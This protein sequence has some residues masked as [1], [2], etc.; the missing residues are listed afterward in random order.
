MA[1]SLNS[2]PT[3]LVLPIAVALGIGLLIGTERERSKGSGPQREIAGVRTFALVSLLG[4]IAAVL[5]IAL[6]T[7]ACALVIS[8]FAVA[9]YLHTRSVDPGITTEV[10]LLVTFALG[11]LCFSQPTIAAGVAVTVTVLL[12]A[13][14]WLHAAVKGG[15]SDSEI[16]D[17]FLLSAAALIVLPLLPDRTIDPWQV[18]NPHNVWRVVVL[19]MAI[20]VLGYFGLKWW[21]PRRG[22]MLA[23][24]LG[25]LVSSTATHGTMGQ[26]SKKQPEL[27]YSSAAA[28]TFSSVTTAVT[29]IAVVAAID[30]TAALGIA[31]AM[32]AASV[33]SALF[34]AVLLVSS[35]GSPAGD[36]ALSSPINLRAALFFGAM[37][38]GV[39][40]V[41]TLLS[42]AFGRNAALASS[43]AAGLADA[44]SGAISAATLASHGILSSP[45]A[46]MA[47]LLSFTANSMTK[48]ILSAATGS[49]RFATLIAL[50]LCLAVSVAW[51][52]WR[53]TDSWSIPAFVQ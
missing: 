9:G 51:A 16:Y 1:T 19:V 20:N 7:A 33:T 21:G 40:I 53:L 23:G 41:A 17:L 3:E 14:N 5:G 48:T 29:M 50:G 13:R 18:F 38:S 27:S 30:E 44:H 10:A 6:L 47:V 45:D 31:P 32:L 37:V 39:L 34:A 15:L 22:L 25:G 46:Q 24:L 2:D 35:H 49:R 8:G 11:V 42:R 28:A 52:A 36:V 43:A 4:V 12:A 26:Q